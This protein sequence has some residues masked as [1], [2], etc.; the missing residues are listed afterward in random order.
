MGSAFFYFCLLTGPAARVIQ[1]DGAPGRT[2]AAPT[3]LLFERRNQGAPDRFQGGTG[4]QAVVGESV[5]KAVLFLTM[6]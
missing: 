3:V 1:W 2:R 6:L 4:T 5:P